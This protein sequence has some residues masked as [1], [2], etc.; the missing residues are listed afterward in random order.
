MLR[1][2]VLA[3]SPV[4]CLAFAHA[5]AADELRLSVDGVEREVLVFPPS[6]TPVGTNGA[7]APKAPLLFA[8]H[9]HGGS[10][11]EAASDMLFQNLWPEAIVNSLYARSTYWESMSIRWESGA[12][13]SRNLISLVTAT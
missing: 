4:L 1:W 5:A 7:A 13:G 2:G 11:E 12:A 9:P 10:A 3:F 6:K 8:F